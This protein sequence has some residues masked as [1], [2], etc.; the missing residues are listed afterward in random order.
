MCLFVCLK[1]IALTSI[2]GNDHSEF[3]FTKFVN[4][5]TRLSKPSLILIDSI[6]Q[7]HPGRNAFLFY[8]CGLSEQSLITMT[9][10]HM[11]NSLQAFYCPLSHAHVKAF[12]LQDISESFYV[13]YYSCIEWPSVN[14][15]SLLYSIACFINTSCLYSKVYNLS[16]FF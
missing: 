4:V 3:P 10:K 5:F 15:Y 8:P 11:V 2:I 1:L 13:K 9:T 7:S 6:C 12:C 14:T 16:L